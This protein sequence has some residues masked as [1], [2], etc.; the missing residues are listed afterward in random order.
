M[1]NGVIK[2]LQLIAGYLNEDND[3]KTIYSVNEDELDFNK[4]EL[5]PLAN[6]RF[7]GNDFDTNEI[8]YEVIYIDQRK[9]SKKAITD[10]FVGNDNRWDNWTQAHSVL[11][12][13]V[14][15]LS[16]IRNDDNILLVNSGSPILIDNA[17]SNGLDGMSL[18]ITLYV[19]SNN[20]VCY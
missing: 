13:L 6:I 10:K 3:V 14:T 15:K 19:N 17:F 9:N 8:T 2:G 1:R 18:L 4:K 7:N 5:Y 20:S 11:N 16:L 12:N